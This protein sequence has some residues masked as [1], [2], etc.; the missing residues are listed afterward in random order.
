M[1]RR[2]NA[3]LWENHREVN[4]QRR[5]QQARHDACPI[6]F[7]VEGAQL[8]GVLKRVQHERNQA[9]NIEVHG[10]CGVPP[11]HENKYPDEEVEKSDDTQIILERSGPRSGHRHQFRVERATVPLDAVAHLGPNAQAPQSLGHLHS[12]LNSVSVDCN[13]TVVRPNPRAVGGRCGA[14]VPRHHAASTVQPRHAVVGYYRVGSLLEVDREKYNSRHRCGGEHHSPKPYAEAIRHQLSV[15]C[16][17]G[18]SPCHDL[19]FD[20]HPD[21]LWA[22]SPA[23]A[24]DVPQITR[25]GLLRSIPRAL[26]TCHTRSNSDTTGYEFQSA[27]KHQSSKAIV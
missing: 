24:S 19:R 15:P 25:T 21:P 6:N 9:E 22:P 27:R 17:L 2:R 18:R 4:Q 13:Q 3:P 14:H 23:Y 11:A 26:P 12:P 1:T 20:S 10:A 7:P 5:L 16:W 8:A